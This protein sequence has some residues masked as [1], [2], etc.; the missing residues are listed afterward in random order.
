MKVNKFDGNIREYFRKV[1]ENKKLFDVTLATDDGEHV[2][3]HKIVLS[4]ESKFFEDIFMK[5]DQPNMLIYLKRITSH[6]LQHILNFIYNGEVSVAEEEV[7]LFLE[8]GKELQIKGLEEAFLT[9]PSD[10]QIKNREQHRENDDKTLAK[11]DIL[12]ESNVQLKIEIQ[13][14]NS[15]L[16]DQIQKM[17]LKTKGGYKCNICGRISTK[18]RKQSLQRHAETHIMGMSLHCNQCDKIC[19]TRPSLQ[20]HISRY[21]KKN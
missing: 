8:S 19:S 5:T 10:S 14:E 1:R 18:N 21:H 12:D 9:L 2:Q 15:E 13:T 17:V 11:D 20:K 3:A 4:T 7:K 6:Q 16:D